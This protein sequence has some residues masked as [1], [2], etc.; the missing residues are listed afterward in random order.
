MSLLIVLCFAAVGGGSSSDSAEESKNKPCANVS[1]I[2]HNDEQPDWCLDLINDCFPGGR[3][4]LEFELSFDYPSE[5]F[6]RIFGYSVWSASKCQ[7]HP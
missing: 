3:L 1:A 4:A 5:D 6:G 2:H 7:S